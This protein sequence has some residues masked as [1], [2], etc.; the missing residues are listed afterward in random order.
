M[1]HETF[2]ILLAVANVSIGLVTAWENIRF[3]WEFGRMNGSRHWVTLLF[4]FVEFY[5]AMV[6]TY[7]LFS[8]TIKDPPSWHSG[9][10]WPAITV[11]LASGA[12]SAIMRRKAYGRRPS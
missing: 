8:P 6:F 7:V 9:F 12:A 5:W 4:A 3:Y 2:R 11:T 10:I 1:G